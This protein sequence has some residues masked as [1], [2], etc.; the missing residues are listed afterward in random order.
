MPRT[1]GAGLFD[2][3]N[4]HGMR[5]SGVGKEPYLP[6]RCS[7]FSLVRIYFAPPYARIR[8]AKK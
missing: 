2:F 7:H 6:L 5:G 8:Q 1:F 3:Y 4:G